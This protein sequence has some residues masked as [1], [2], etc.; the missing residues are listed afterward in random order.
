MN[1]R[2]FSLLCP[3]CSALCASPLVLHGATYVV[4]PQGNDA[5]PGTA[6]KPFRGI[7]AAV[8]VAKAGDTVLV[9]PGTY[10]GGIG[11]VKTGTADQR[12]VVKATGDGCFSPQ[13]LHLK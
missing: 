6:A 10:P 1:D 5:S 2:A 7:H 9:K 4:S 13:I 12:V 3:L 11:L 8:A